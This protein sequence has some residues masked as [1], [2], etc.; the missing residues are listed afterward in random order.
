VARPIE[1]Y[2]LLSD[3]R[4]S[5]LVSRHGSI[6]WLCAPR[7]DSAAVFARLLGR[8]EH[9]FWSIR[10][11]G[12]FRVERKYHD[13]TMVLETR[14]I[15]SAG[16]VLLQ[17]ALIIH[18]PTPLLVR[19]ISGIRGS[20]H[21]QTH[22]A[23][24]PEYGS[25]IPWVRR[26]DYGLKAI[27]GPD[28]WN[29]E[30]PVPLTG[31]DMTSGADFTLG[32]GERIAFALSWHPS[33]QSTFQPCPDMQEALHRTLEY[34]RSQAARCRYQGPHRQAVLR[35]V[36][37]LKALIYEPTGAIVAAPTTSLPEQIGGTRNWDYRYCWI[38]DA[39][40]SFDALMLAGYEQEARRWIAWL[41]KAVAGS[42]AQAHMLYGV[43][44]ER[45]LVESE[46]PWLPG[47]EGS[48]P[49]RVGNAAYNQLQNDVFGQVVDTLHEAVKNEVPVGEDAWRIQANL[50]D[51][52]AEIWDEPD[53]GI[54]ETRG[55]RQHFTHS[56]LMAWVAVDRAIRNARMLGLD[57]PVKAWQ[58]LKARIHADICER[59]FSR[60]RNAFVQSYGAEN[61]D[62]SLLLMPVL[63][64]LPADDPRIIGTVTAVERELVT[65]RYVRRYDTD[66]SDDGVGG[67]EGAF[68]ACSF[69]LAD[70]WILMGRMQEAA[71]L[72][73]HLLSLRN[74]LGLLSE[75]YD[76]VR[77]RLTGNFPQAFSHIALINTAFTL[78]G[79]NRPTGN[80]DAAG[81]KYTRPTEDNIEERGYA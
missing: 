41:I 58:K 3:C 2:A 53:E 4:G 81:G 30:S 13:N 52:L 54:W 68:I 64:F 34:W 14:F 67:H 45:R 66:T 75:E 47:Y 39:T 38:R 35:S 37:T 32:A 17:D 10:P 50:I 43:A 49:V 25:I 40:F 12:E 60:N 63:G 65:G 70:A 61:L 5:A 9:G 76:P 42:P 24:R 11:Q 33:H 8:D 62:A 72:F 46:L 80:S 74:D 71:E 1:D 56:K 15:S 23:L 48:R 6:D 57:A 18:S 7:F 20:M 51:F 79:E 27:A 28:E 77:R 21:L 22:V 19:T 59:G 16:E 73:E 78:L 36:L 31:E 29:L 26:T 44:G 69:W 55:P